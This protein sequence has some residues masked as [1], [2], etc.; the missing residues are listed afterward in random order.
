MP[1]STSTRLKHGWRPTR[2]CRPS[3]ESATSRRARLAW[4]FAPRHVRAARVTIVCGVCPCVSPC[5]HRL[6][7]LAA[8]RFRRAAP[9]A[10]HA[11]PGAGDQP[12]RRRFAEAGAR[13]RS[14]SGRERRQERRRL[15]SR[16]REELP[17][18][19]EPRR[20]DPRLG[21][22]RPDQEIWRGPQVGVRR[23]D[24][25]DH[26]RSPPLSGRQEP[27]GHRDPGRGHPRRADP[28]G[29]A[30]AAAVRRSCGACGCAAPRLRASAARAPRCRCA[31]A[32]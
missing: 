10:R 14:S 4:H 9:A 29:R 27:L 20:R 22:A 15:L 16:Q 12:R 2:R 7:S 5:T 17:L 24:G 23:Q 26:R 8:R 1:G 18:A 11:H 30:S 21:D 32:G 25:E 3:A 28:L 31:N 13:G 19:C 6:L